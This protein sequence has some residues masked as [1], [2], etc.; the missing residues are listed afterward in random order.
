MRQIL[1]A[2][3]ATVAFSAVAADR[4]KVSD[5]GYDPEDSTA[6]IRKALDSGAKTVVFDRQEG[7][8][9]TDGIRLGSHIEIVLEEGVEI[10]ARKGGII[11][12]WMSLFDLIDSKDVTIRGE[13]KGATLRMRR[14]DYG[15]EP[16]RFSEHRHGINMLSA[17]RI[18]IEN[19]RIVDT[20]GDGIYLGES[21][22]KGICKEGERGE[23]G[24]CRDIVIR[25]CD[26][27][28]NHRQG[29]SVISAENM[30]I[31]DT[32]L[33]NTLGTAPRAGID[34]EPNFERNKLVNC[35][36]R[37]CLVENNVGAGYEFY[38]A[39]MGAESAPISV[40]IENCRSVGNSSAVSIGG[41]GREGDFAGGLISFVN[42]RFESPRVNGI[43]IGAKP[44]CAYQVKFTDCTVSNAAKKAVSFS[45]RKPSQ[46]PVDNVD[47]GNLIVHG[48]DEAT[49]FGKA[50]IGFG[51]SPRDI[52][53]TVTL[54][55]PDGKRRAVKLDA[56]W[57]KKNMPAFQN[58]AMPPVRAVLPPLAAVKVE[59]AS[60]GELVDL[61]PVPAIRN[62]RY[63][64]FAEAGKVRLV[65]RQVV[66]KKAGNPPLKPFTVQRLEK[67]Q[68]V[69]EPIS[70]SLPG[71]EPTAIDF[72]VP[73]RG[74]YAIVLPRMRGQFLLEK[75]SVP[76]ALDATQ[77]QNTI[78]VVDERPVSMTFASTGHPFQILGVG[79]SYDSFVFR[80]TDPA[81]KVVLEQETGNDTVSVRMPDG[82]L[83]G[84]WKVEAAKG[85]TGHYASVFIDV[86][87]TGGYLFLS[88]AKRWR[89]ACD[90]VKVS[91]FGYDPVDATRFI[92]TALDSGAKRIVL[93]RQAGPWNTLT[94]YQRSNTELVVEPG[95]EL[96]AKRGAFKGLRDY[97][98]VV[99]AV[100]NV[101]IR[102][103]EGSAFRMW[104]QDYQGPDYE[105]GEW[106]YALRLHGCTN[107]VVEGLR[108]CSSGGDGI[109]VSG[110]DITIRKCVC[111]DNHRQ[112]IS[113][114]DV[115][116]LLIEDTV[117][118]NTKGTPPQAGIDF[119]PDRNKWKMSNVVM[120]N[121]LFENNAGNGI[122]LYLNQLRDDSEPVSMRFENCRTVGNGTSCVVNPGPR[123]RNH[124]GGKVE[125]TGC[126]FEG[127]RR[128][129][130]ALSHKTAEAFDV[131]F[132]DCVVSNAA[133]TSVSFAVDGE[134]F[135]GPPDGIDLGNLTVFQN[136]E[137]PWFRLNRSG[138]G[139]LAERIA[140]EV[141]VVGP[142]GDRKVVK[143]D[144]A[145]V[146][147]NMPLVNGGKMPPPRVGCPAAEAVTIVDARPGE[148]VDLAPAAVLG[149]IRRYVFFAEKKGDVRFV[150]RQFTPVP[151]RQ[152]SKLPIEIGA[153]KA[154]GKIGKPVT[155]PQ[156]G[157]EST[158]IV[159]KAPRRGFYAMVLP[160]RAKTRFTLEKSSVPVA[161]DVSQGAATV[162]GIRAKPF[163][164]W[165]Q[166]SADKRFFAFVGGSDYYRFRCALA[167]PAGKAFFGKDMID[168]VEM[169]DS[170]ATPSE[171]LWRFDFAKA[172]EPNYDFIDVDLTGIPGLFFLS[173]EK[174]WK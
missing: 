166:A 168:N 95:V 170:G 36:M 28:T 30:L 163:S 140:G 101:R 157:N 99:D 43:S 88:E 97:L 59:D 85:K 146:A 11:D 9:Y 63:V 167:D 124:V 119:E 121:C 73:V 142:K 127:A 24:P 105:H 20:G 92:Q 161:I 66:G 32:V 107:A 79:N 15:K 144:R 14:E 57:A 132:R 89:T 78:K 67:A 81:G 18:T 29:I 153:L 134:D 111:D 13:G 52:R 2:V 162:A 109:G 131:S 21:C 42:C 158:E 56:D 104:K 39:N 123:G 120:R 25:R 33:R 160:K 108:I 74:F 129:G 137:R 4:V 77:K 113:V 171:G 135:S 128:S 41:G 174:Y 148:L 37:N 164:L 118:S 143:M 48:A 7:P 40:V 138:F 150:G 106:R 165:F 110:K 152:L 55:A 159:F 82:N 83:P 45:T 19:L 91:D 64:F 84:F 71:L 154:D 22:S 117:M 35:V 53:G 115:D 75:S 145:W 31:E 26:C 103:G 141:T 130:I 72:D 50:G 87:G 61:S 102:G 139:P 17:E 136:E 100:E 12:V 65:A 151:K 80:L 112:G 27:D 76:I 122:E 125:F 16:Y 155:V 49:W 46:G 70:L 1:A 149:R 47:L 96:V 133:G 126:S 90:E 44:G 94:V 6:I 34:F 172:K 5:F 8:W 54:V 58:G 156:P 3:A 69:G 98:Y 86:F 10:V 51:P 23:N 114:F 38:L 173:P 116:G 93:D 169:I 62:P 147:E 68:L 60:P